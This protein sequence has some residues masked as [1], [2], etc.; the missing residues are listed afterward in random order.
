MFNKPLLALVAA[1]FF[2]LTIAMFFN[3]SLNTKLTL[4]NQTIGQLQSEKANFE[5]LV[6]SQNSALDKLKA[7]QLV[8]EKKA[9]AAIARATKL[10]KQNDELAW[11]LL[12][13]QPANPNDLCHSLDQELNEY[14][15]NRFNAYK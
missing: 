14:L 10:A 2:A 8:K 11:Q 15:R 3:S 9:N 1:L 6:S 4:A 12:N 5:V 7:E 13:K